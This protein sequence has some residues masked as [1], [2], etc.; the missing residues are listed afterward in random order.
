MCVATVIIVA[1]GAVT[2]AVAAKQSADA[3]K[4]AQA[5]QTSAANEA[6]ALQ[7]SQYAQSRAEFAPYQNAAAEAIGRMQGMTKQARMT[8][9]PNNASSWQGAPVGSRDMQTMT[10]GSQ[11]GL[12]TREADAFGGGAAGPQ[13]TVQQ[14]G[15]PMAGERM[16]G[17][18]QPVQAAEPSQP[19]ETQT[20][21]MQA[22]D[23][24]PPR[25]VPSH[26]VQQLIAKGAKV[27][28]S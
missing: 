9:D 11:A 19:A 6:L 12:P 14:L 15:A 1:A 25:P 28:Q 23:G 13:A 8:F 2:S 26:L 27:I 4:R 7:K 20:V 17:G 3:S 24:S 16:L 22:P 21:L 18:A 5:A 10:A